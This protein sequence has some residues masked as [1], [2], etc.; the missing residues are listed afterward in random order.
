MIV[1]TGLTSAAIGILML[2]RQ[3]ETI[4]GLPYG[5]YTEADVT[6][7]FRERVK[8]N[9]PDQLKPGE[10]AVDVTTIQRARDLCMNIAKARGVPCPDCSGTGII[11]TGWKVLPCKRCN[12]TGRLTNVSD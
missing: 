10:D 4:L 11:N 9:H 12:K 3:A 6:A 1:L 8:R 7:A 5:R 2:Q